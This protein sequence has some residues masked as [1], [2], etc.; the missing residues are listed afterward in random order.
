[1]IPS[2]DCGARMSTDRQYGFEQ[3]EIEVRGRRG[4]KTIE[5]LKRIESLPDPSQA[6]VVCMNAM[7][8][9]RVGCL[10]NE[11]NP[12]KDLP[13]FV[14]PEGARNARGTHGPVFVDNADILLENL[15]G[16]QVDFVTLTGRHA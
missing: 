13:R 7:E 12:G 3:R 16:R 15:I 11:R 4:G 14:T 8:A 10:Y 6:V 1:M 9:A 2:P 5:M